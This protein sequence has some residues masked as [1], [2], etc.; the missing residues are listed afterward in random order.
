M[1]Q[2]LLFFDCVS[3]CYHDDSGETEVLSDFTL[4][5]DSGEFLALLGPSGC[6]KSTVLS[7]A[8]G[9]L[10]PDSGRVTLR[11]QEIRRPPLHMGYMLQRDHLFPWLTVRENALLG[12]RVR[13][14][15]PSAR[16]KRHV[17]DL[18]AACGLTEFADALPGAWNPTRR[19]YGLTDASRASVQTLFNI[20]PTEAQAASSSEP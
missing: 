9:L 16:Q 1:D 8:A 15:E 2:P 3:M 18:L 10:Q 17:E 6:G 14:K 7:L 11:G 12:I 5:V 13:Q 4:R 19:F 20:W